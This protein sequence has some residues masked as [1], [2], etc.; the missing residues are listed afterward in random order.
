MNGVEEIYTSFSRGMDLPPTPDDPTFAEVWEV[1]TGVLHMVGLRL[2]EADLGQHLDAANE[3]RL[4][5]ERHHRVANMAD[6]MP[7]TVPAAAVRGLR[8]FGNY[9]ENS[10][11]LEEIRA[12]LSFNAGIADI[13]SEYAV[14][15]RGRAALP[16]KYALSV[17][18]KS[19][20]LMSDCVGHELKI[21]TYRG[22]S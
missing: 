3:V 5:L 16:V 15:H 9:L 13:F 12:Y 22:I 17:V 2:L 14:K 11:Q 7:I 18:A 6:G 19:A 20:A 10:N 4:Q 1:H 8:T 21:F